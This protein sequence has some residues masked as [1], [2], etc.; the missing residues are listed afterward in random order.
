MAESEGFE[1][2]T[3]EPESP[4]LPIILT[5]YKNVEARDGTAPSSRGYKSLILLLN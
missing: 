5:L 4:V 3:G 1:P 2:S